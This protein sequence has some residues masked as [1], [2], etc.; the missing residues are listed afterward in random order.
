MT[1]SFWSPST[2]AK[3]CIP[4]LWSWPM[5]HYYLAI[6]NPLKLINKSCS[7][8]S[9]AFESVTITTSYL[10]TITSLLVRNSKLRPFGTYWEHLSDIYLRVNPWKSMNFAQGLRLN[11]EL[12][13]TTEISVAFY[14]CKSY[15]PFLIPASFRII[16]F[17]I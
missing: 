15:W 2:I 14:F 16:F 8:L 3:T 7:F 10:V 6:S 4:H 12:R 5:Q 11:R 17:S 9:Y 1:I 13:K